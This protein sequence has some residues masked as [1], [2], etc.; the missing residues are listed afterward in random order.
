M[1]ARIDFLVFLLLAAG[2]ASAAMNIYLMRHRAIVI[3]FSATHTQPVSQLPTTVIRHQEPSTD[4]GS[5]HIF[6]ERYDVC[7]FA[8][9]ICWVRI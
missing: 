1:T 4:F 5:V 6:P 2:L 3:N 7:T 9:A 8:N